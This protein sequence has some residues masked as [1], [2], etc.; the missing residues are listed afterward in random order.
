PAGTTV[1]GFTK[2]TKSGGRAG[3]LQ[4]ADPNAYHE[5]WGVGLVSDADR[6]AGGSQSAQVTQFDMLA[7][8]VQQIMQAA[9]AA[10]AGFE[11][12]SCVSLAR[13]Y[14]ALFSVAGAP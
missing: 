14:P 10:V 13:F 12:S 2:Q 11:N 8:C 4:C 5:Q 6:A 3:D 7:K 9:P 1:N